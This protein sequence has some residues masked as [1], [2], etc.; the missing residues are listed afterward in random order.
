MI[1]CVVGRILGDLFGCENNEG[2]LLNDANL[3]RRYGTRLMITEKNVRAHPR[4]SV[5]LCAGQCVCKLVQQ[6]T[7]VT[8]YADWPAYLQHEQVPSAVHAYPIQAST[9]D[10]GTDGHGHYQQRHIVTVT[11]RSR[12][13][14]HKFSPPCAMAGDAA[15]VRRR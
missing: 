6:N 1:I 12:F 15:C 8:I 13:C 10:G 7:H 4:N 11:M 14:D 2:R 9:R 5:C 3:M